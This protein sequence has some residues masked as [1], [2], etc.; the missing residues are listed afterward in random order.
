MT[1]TYVYFLVVVIL[2]A[3][4]IVSAWRTL[5]VGTAMAALVSLAIGAAIS[6]RRLREYRR[7][8]AIKTFECRVGALPEKWQ[9]PFLGKEDERRT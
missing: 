8:A 3:A 5:G 4:G 6:F 2:M 9:K 7:G 1:R